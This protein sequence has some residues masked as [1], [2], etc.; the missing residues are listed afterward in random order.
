VLPDNTEQQPCRLPSTFL[1]YFIISISSVLLHTS[2]SDS[3]SP[4][5]SLLLP[6]CKY[7]ISSH[8]NAR[9]YAGRLHIGVTSTV[10]RSQ[11]MFLQLYRERRTFWSLGLTRTLF[12]TYIRIDWTACR[13]LRML[14]LFMWLCGSVS[15]TVQCLWIM[16]GHVFILVSTV[17]RI[18][19]MKMNTYFY[20]K[21]LK[22]RKLWRLV[23]YMECNIKVEL[24]EIVCLYVKHEECC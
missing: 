5:S 17:L 4:S 20:F 3:F 10:L 6:P 19:E 15:C 9:L 22:T 11:L 8:P 13:C 18:K 2:I 12:F 1:S 23:T 16:N 24:R 21:N 7:P 14:Y